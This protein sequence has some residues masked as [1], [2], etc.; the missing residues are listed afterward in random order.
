M[1]CL[2]TKLTIDSLENIFSVE[3]MKL[4]MFLMVSSNLRTLDFRPTNTVERN[5]SLRGK[6]SFAMIYRITEHPCYVNG[7]YVVK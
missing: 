6:K 1:Y 7:N 3:N 2:N 4:C 5:P